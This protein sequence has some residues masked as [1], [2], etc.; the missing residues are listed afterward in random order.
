MFDRVPLG[1]SSAAT[2]IAPRPPRARRVIGVALTLLAIAATVREARVAGAPSRRLAVDPPPALAGSWHS[3]ANGD[4]VKRIY[5]DGDTLW[6]AAQ[7]G[8]LVRWSISAGTYTQYLHPQSPLPDN[9]VYDVAPAVGGGVWAATGRGLARFVPERDQWQVVTP[10]TS[11]GMPARVVTAIA[12]LADGT[13]WVGFS[14]EWDADRVHPASSDGSVHGAFRPGGVARFDPSRNTW[15][16]SAV[17]EI[18]FVPGEASG[19]H[20]FRT[21]P[22][23]N[24]TALALDSA[25]T[26][27][28]GT[29]PYYAWDATDCHDSDC[30]SRSD[31]WI[32]VGGGLAALQGETWRRWYPTSETDTSCYDRTITSLAADADERLWAGTQGHGV[33]LMRGFSQGWSCSS[34]QAYY[35]KP[36]GRPDPVNPGL[37]GNVVRA[38]AVEPGGGRIFVSQG[39][40]T[41]AG[42]G[43]SILDPKGTYDDSPGSPIAFNS[44]DLYTSLTL[45]PTA[46]RDRLASAIDVSNGLVVGTIDDQ[47]GDGDGLLLGAPNPSATGRYDWR[48]LRTADHGLPSNQIADIADDAAGGATWFALK[49]RGVARWLHDGDQW[50]WWGAY[51]DA[52]RVA[53]TVVDGVDGANR[54]VV[55]IASQAAFDLRFPDGEPIVRIGDDATIHRVTAFSANGDGQ[56]GMLTLAPP[57]DA[58]VAAG[59]GVVRLVRGPAGDHA[60]QIALRNGSEPWVSALRNDR[61]YQRTGTPPTCDRYPD[62]WQDG[63]ASGLVDGRWRVYDPSNSPLAYREAVAIEADST[64]KVW[65]AVGNLVA[66]GF[67]LAVLDPASGTWRTH[68]VTADFN[69]GNGVADLAVDPVNGYVWTAHYPVERKVS[70]GPGQPEQIVVAGGGVARWDGTR[71][72]S[73]TKKDSGSTMA[74]FGDYGVYNAVTIDRGR[75]RVWAGGWATIGSTFHWPRGENV[76]AQLDACPLE[77]CRAKDWTGKRFLGDGLVSAL[78]VDAL[79]RLWVGTHRYHRGVVPPIGGVKLLVGA[80]WYRIGPDDSA[81][82]SNQ[83]SSIDA[84]GPSVWL[85]TLRNGAAVY[86]EAIIPTATPTP[87]IPTAAPTLTPTDTPTASSTPSPTIDVDA[88][89]TETPV[90]TPSVTPNA[91][92]SATRTGTLE[93]TPDPR[94]SASSTEGTPQAT[95]TAGTPVSRCGPTGRCTISLPFLATYARR[96]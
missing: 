91:T 39:E 86:D 37:L 12:P 26:L 67:G 63:G 10:S 53:V 16:M 7:A 29:R 65:I 49:N 85:G 90:T 57:L 31:Y 40:G 1:G 62:C 17:A 35:I 6:V 2:P 8:G 22:S 64:G 59:A 73:W 44:D 14:Q 79:G 96:R 38:V 87:F 92:P 47:N 50:T 45:G 75:D 74:T 23:D 32:L 60:T 56:N 52:G 20:K 66:T 61:L 55:D 24:V 34:G 9:T 80:A 36:R 58:D 76:H 11:P 89:A 27:W 30:L 88:T 3:V 70:I 42:L 25:G 93:P 54:V 84:G 19:D 15:S 33:L 13:L 94:A 43:L 77:T 4:R 95:P 69:A 81:L 41:D 5:R 21:L 18:V 46:V 48:N 28:V 51:Q 83:I 82:G 68:Q 78:D 72:K 71:W